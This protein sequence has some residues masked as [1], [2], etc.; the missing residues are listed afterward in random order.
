LK[1]RASNQQG[2]LSVHRLREGFKEERTALINRI[3]GLLAEF[4]WCSRKAGALLF[5]VRFRTLVEARIH[6]GLRGG[7]PRQ[8]A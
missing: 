8:A 1:F 4:A 6:A 2:Q 5:V 3:P 7:T